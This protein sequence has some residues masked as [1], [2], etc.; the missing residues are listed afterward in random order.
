MEDRCICCGSVI[1]EG[2]Q[3]CP[4]CLVARK[5]IPTEKSAE[6]LIAEFD[7]KIIKIK[8]EAIQIKT[9]CLICGE[10]V[11]VFGFGYSPKICEKCKSAVMKVREQDG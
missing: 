8:A 1:P 7:S 10:G 3:V 11:P 2:R 4:N 5:K 6:Q 9:P